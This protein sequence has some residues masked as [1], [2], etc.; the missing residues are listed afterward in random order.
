LAWFLSAKV[1][2][3]TAMQHFPVSRSLQPC[4]A[5]GRGTLGWRRMCAGRDDRGRL[6]YSP[7][8]AGGANYLSALIVADW[9]GDSSIYG[10]AVDIS[11]ALPY[12]SLRSAVSGITPSPSKPN[13]Y[14]Y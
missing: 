3:F 5:S 7:C 11:T 2:I 9:D 14:S 8:V 10:N 1:A 4:R 12:I 13:D 6:G